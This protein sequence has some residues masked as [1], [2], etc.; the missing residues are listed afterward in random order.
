MKKCN[1]QQQCSNV[2]FTTVSLTNAPR[3][4]APYGNHKQ[5]GYPGYTADRMMG[6]A[7]TAGGGGAGTMGKVLTIG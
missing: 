1:I 5:R 7:A 2:L 4:R 6:A 3:S